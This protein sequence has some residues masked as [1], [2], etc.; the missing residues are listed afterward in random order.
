MGNLGQAIVLKVKVRYICFS[1]I[2]CLVLRS[3]GLS[4]LNVVG[5]P[6]ISVI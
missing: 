2:L 5:F 1:S 4:C 3:E 6:A